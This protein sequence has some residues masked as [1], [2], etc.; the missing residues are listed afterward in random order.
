[1]TLQPGC[2]FTLAPHFHLSVEWPH[3]L[4]V[5]AGVEQHDGRFYPS[6]SWRPPTTD[7]LSVLVRASD[8][9]A[10]PEELEACVCLFQLPR[11]LG[12]EWWN[13]LERAAETL[14]DGR[15]PGFDAFVSQVVEFLAF[16]DLPVSEGARCDLVAKNPGPQIVHGGRE[17][18]DL[19]G[20]HCS[21]A[22]RTPW[23]GGVALRGPGLWGAINLGDEPTSVVLINLSCRQ[24]D[25]ELLRRFPDHPLP[26]TVGELASQFLRS[27][28]DYPTV[29]VILGPGDG[30]RLPWGGLIVDS[31]S[32]G[33]QE[34][35]MLM[36]ISH[37]GTASA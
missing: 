4:L 28:P 29:R 9:P 37:E 6:P 2:R 26:A 18:S 36:L 30:C 27:C 1:M 35:E 24:L 16:K 31:Y 11:H 34:P 33:K 13:L 10:A 8:E 21:L 15:L 20:L 25:A 32:Q 22:P 23:P 14:G 12:S 5:G 3:R 17:V 7:E 19:V